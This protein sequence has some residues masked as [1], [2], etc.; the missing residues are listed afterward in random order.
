MHAV[1]G[2]VKIHDVNILPAAFQCT[3]LTLSAMPTP[4][5][6]DDTTCPVL[7]G[8]PVNVQVNATAAVDT[9]AT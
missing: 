1:T 9:C 8:M 2:K 5:M 7:T 3:A 6:L 4:I